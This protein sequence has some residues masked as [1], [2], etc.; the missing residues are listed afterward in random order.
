M[1]EK[2]KYSQIKGES[3]LNSLSEATD[4]MTNKFEEYNRERQEKD[5]IID[6]LKSDIVNMNAKIE[7]L[8]RIVGRQE[9][10]SRRNC[11]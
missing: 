2:T 5:K 9:Q 4:F 8:Q 10:Y 1:R 6:S 7:K 11:L 3:Q